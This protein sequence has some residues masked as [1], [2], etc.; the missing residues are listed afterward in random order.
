MSST[1]RI[2][3][4]VFN[5]FEQNTYLIYDEESRE[6]FI[7]DPGN[8]NPA[9]DD[10]LERF[11]KEHDLRLTKILNTHGHIDHVFGISF[12]K[13]IFNAEFYFPFPD[14]PLLENI[15]YQSEMIGINAPKTFKPDFDLHSF[16]K[17]YLNTIPIEIIK[18]P[19]HSPG[20]TCLVIKEIKKIFTGD[21]IFFESVGRTDLWGGDYDLLID[22]IKNK[23][24]PLGDD[25]EILPGHGPSTTIKHEKIN[26]PYLK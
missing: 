26:N 21:T 9:E 18:T 6:A 16:D 24:L 15:K 8:S 10:E 5:D 11:I 7:I 2:E 12:I 19:G 23:I 4:F 20:G 14:L 1:I 17:L 3:K 25:F 13:E 22:S